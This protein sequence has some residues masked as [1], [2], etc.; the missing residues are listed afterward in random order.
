[1]AVNVLGIILAYHYLCKL[2]TLRQFPYIVPGYIIFIIII[3]IIRCNPECY[4]YF[5][6]LHILRRI[7]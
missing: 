6:Y 5:Y 3:F 1:M 7:L 2:V 4:I